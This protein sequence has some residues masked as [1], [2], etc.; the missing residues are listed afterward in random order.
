MRWIC[1]MLVL[2]VTGCAMPRY[3]RTNVE[4]RV[5]VLHDFCPKAYLSGRADHEIQR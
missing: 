1:I 5:E 4:L 3:E 2:F